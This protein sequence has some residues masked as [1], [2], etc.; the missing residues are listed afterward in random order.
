MDGASTAERSDAWKQEKLWAAAGLL[1][2]NAPTPAPA[3]NSAAVASR[4]LH[5]GSRLNWGWV[6]PVSDPRMGA[7]N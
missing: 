4:P 1:C 2:F 5:W 3:P 7:Y 6:F